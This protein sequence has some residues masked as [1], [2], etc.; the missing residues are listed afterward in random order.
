M[1]IF[2]LLLFHL[3]YF[4]SLS[5][6]ICALFQFS[7][8]INPIV[9]FFLIKRRTEIK[10]CS[11]AIRYLII[12]ICF[13]DKEFHARQIINY[14]GFFRTHTFFFLRKF[15]NKKSSKDLCFWSN[16]EWNLKKN[17]KHITNVYLWMNDEQ[18]TK[19]K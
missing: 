9:F 13:Y 16:N 8:I 4:V 7:N 1:K 17:Q 14:W 6:S 15:V 10:P 19:V 11:G 12:T 5:Q 2:L 18:K 3:F